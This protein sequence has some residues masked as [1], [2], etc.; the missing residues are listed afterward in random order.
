[1]S[2]AQKS[3]DRIREVIPLASILFKYGYKVLDDGGHREQQFSC[4]LH[5]DGRD[6]A[7]SARLYP[8]SN[9]FYCFACGRARDSI[10]LVREKEGLS[11]WNAVRKLEKE[12]GLP[13]LPW[14]HY[15]AKESL[16]DTLFAVKGQSPTQILE[17]AERFIQNF[18][19]DGKDAF[20]I[21]RF[22][23]AH[24]KVA[25]YIQKDNADE[26]VG[27]KLAS[28]VLDHVKKFYSCTN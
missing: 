14:E 5:G 4:D 24:D 10:T 16:A 17:R 8:D 27:I 23:E 26:E 13:S 6:S 3:A 11:F 21:A 9:K 12:Y 28:Q 2:R 7:P 18:Y 1:M 25:W 20:E 15:E 22:W 19:E